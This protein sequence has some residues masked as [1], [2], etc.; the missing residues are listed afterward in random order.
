VNTFFRRTA[1]SHN[2]EIFT[3]R[4]NKLTLC[5]FKTNLPNKCRISN[6][7]NVYIHIHQINEKHFKATNQK[8]ILKNAVIRMS[9]H[10]D[11][12]SWGVGKFARN[13]Y[14]RQK[15]R[16]KYEHSSR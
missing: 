11:D 1:F 8:H 13:C 2:K 10:P 7:S 3:M 6:N 5:I 14:C 12:T 4:P 16:N 9:T 15:N